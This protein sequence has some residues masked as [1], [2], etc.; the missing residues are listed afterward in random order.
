LWLGHDGPQYDVSMDWLC[1]RYENLLVHI[2]DSN[3]IAKDPKVWGWL[4]C[5][6]HVSDPFTMTSRGKMWIHDL[7]LDYPVQSI[8]P[9]ITHEQSVH[10]LGE[11]SR[12]TK[13]AICTDYPLLFT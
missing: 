4:H 13:G 7:S 8:I 1:K 6:C 12:K 10:Y 2:K 9:I 5:F 3:V 11:N